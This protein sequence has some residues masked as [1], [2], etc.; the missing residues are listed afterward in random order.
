[1]IRQ[2]IINPGSTSTKL[3]VYEDEREVVSESVL[4][5]NE[6]LEACDSMIGQIPMRSRCVRDFISR[7]GLKLGDFDDIMSRGGMIW[8]IPLGGV[9]IREDMV[10]A[11]QNERYA[12]YHASNLGCIIAKELAEEAGIPAFIYDAV[13]AGSLPP[14]A[15]ITG[16]PD[17]QRQSCC[18][19]LNSHAMGRRYAEEHQRRYEDLRLL[20]CH[21]GGGIS[22]CVIDHGR[23]AD[24]IGDDDGAFS[25]ERA[26]MTQ[27]LPIIKMC[28]SGEYTYEDMKK[29]VRGSGGL[30]AYLGT[31][32]VREI[33]KMIYAGSK[34]ALLLYRAQAY[35]IAKGIGELAV[36]TSGSLDAIILT[37]GV[38]HSRMLTG[39]VEDY[40]D[41]IAPVFVYPGEKEMEALALGGLRIM[42]GEEKAQ[43]Y[44]MA[45]DDRDVLDLE[46]L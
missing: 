22:V 46:K 24:S 15:K 10:K 38:A 9:R 37:G 39:M 12:S 40:V 36:V 44:V 31:A 19:V 6:E 21:M 1:M 7:H 16:F 45:E 13:T 2:L 33:E 4:H 30:R 42:R 41:F 28:Y 11:V 8:G 14:I 23:I 34:K 43:E 35:Q 25:P 26:G 17:I 18:H 20:V 3:A 32:D 27:I 5:S 29:L